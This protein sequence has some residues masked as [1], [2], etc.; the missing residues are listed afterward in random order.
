LV[1]AGGF[2]RPFRGQFLK[3]TLFIFGFDL[4]IAQRNGIQNTI[5]DTQVSPT[6]LN[7]MP[8][9]RNRRLAELAPPI[10][11]IEG[12]DGIAPPVDQ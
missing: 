4:S 1:L 12:G 3:I 2:F 11:D 5:W 8:P 6:I 7:E 10:L 9:P